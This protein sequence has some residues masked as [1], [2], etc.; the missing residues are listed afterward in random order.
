M[1]QVVTEPVASDA[2]A[3]GEGEVLGRTPWQIFWGRFKKDKV[4]IGGGVFVIV[5]VLLSLFAP[6]IAHH[7]NHHGPND[8]LASPDPQ[9]GAPALVPSA[10]NAIG[11][12]SGPSGKLWF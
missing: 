11:L 9:T 4:A 1:S 5:L 3:V 8:L 2:I 12:P 10:L 6:F 7:I